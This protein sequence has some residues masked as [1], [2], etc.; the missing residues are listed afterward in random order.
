MS[1]VPPLKLSLMDFS[2]RL[3]VVLT[4][5]VS[6]DRSDCARVSVSPHRAADRSLKSI[7]LLPKVLYETPDLITRIN[8]NYVTTDA[9][10]P[11]GN[12]I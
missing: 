3:I 11:A 2:A 12:H 8:L 7:T 4:Y 5:I 10:V 9:K 6:S 1:L